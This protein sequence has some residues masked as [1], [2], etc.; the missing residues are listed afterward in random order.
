MTPEMQE[1]LY[2]LSLRIDPDP[3]VLFQEIVELI[4]RFYDNTMAMINLLEGD[5]VRFRKIVNARP[6]LEGM[7]T[8]ALQNTF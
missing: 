7:V 5:C 8:L 6:A 4:A 2:Q 3:E 1:A